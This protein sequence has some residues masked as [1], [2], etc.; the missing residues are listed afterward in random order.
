[1]LASH[2]QKVDQVFNADTYQQVRQRG[3]MLHMDLDPVAG[4]NQIR[5]A[6]QAGR[7]GMVGTIDVPAP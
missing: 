3:M 5:L 7:S 2:S 6:V 1:V 4:T